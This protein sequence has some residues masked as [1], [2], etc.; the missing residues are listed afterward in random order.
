MTLREQL[1]KKAKKGRLRAFFIA[2]VF[3]GLLAAFLFIGIRWNTQTPQPIQI[4]VFTPPSVSVAK[5][6]EPPVPEVKPEPT[7]EKPLPPPKPVELPAPDLA[8]EKKKI[9]KQERE[10]EKIELER[11]EKLKAEKKQLE[12]EV[13]EKEKARKETEKL[14]AEKL[15]ADKV[16]TEKLET[17]KRETKQQ[18]RIKQLQQQAGATVGAT[19][20]AKTGVTDAD[21]VGRLIS[22]I[23]RNTVFSAGEVDGNPIASFVV[24]LNPDCSIR[25]VRL[26]K[27]SRASAWDQAAERAIRKTDPFPKPTGGNCPARMDVTHRPQQ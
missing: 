7:V 10:K 9:E 5:P 18:E 25:S 22:V 11:K 12:K 21:Y 4:E 27:S 14:N 6:V 26:T 24:E 17:E 2:L 20:G 8:I 23:S 1:A 13:T 15:A 16:K 19:E 3:H